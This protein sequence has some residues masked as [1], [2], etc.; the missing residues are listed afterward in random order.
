ALALV[1]S[2]LRDPGFGRWD[3]EQIRA[4]VR[5]HHGEGMGGVTV[6]DQD[7]SLRFFE[8]VRRLM[9]IPTQ[10]RLFALFGVFGVLL[11]PYQTFLYF[12][13][14]ERW[15]LGPGQRGLFFAASAAASIVSLI[16]FGKRGEARFR[17][18]PARLLR[19]TG[20]LLALAVVLI[21]LGGVSPWLWGM[22]LLFAT[23][24]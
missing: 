13:L 10:R 14:E 6:T 17:E 21:G 23:S 11:I 9:M 24:Q 3:T 22:V 18:N 12:F 16:F 2:R 15:G 7:V 5:E 1:A 20:A 19:L 4:T 8:I